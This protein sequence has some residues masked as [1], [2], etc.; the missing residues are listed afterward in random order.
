LIRASNWPVHL[1]KISGEVVAEIKET[2][3]LSFLL[4]F[5]MV[6]TL[7]ANYCKLFPAALQ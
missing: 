1:L 4:G 2:N 3:G 7:T 5:I 6:A